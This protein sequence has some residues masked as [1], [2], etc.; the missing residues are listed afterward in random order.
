MYS[1]FKVPGPSILKK[2]TKWLDEEMQNPKRPDGKAIDYGSRRS[3]SPKTDAKVTFH[4]WVVKSYVRNNPEWR[5]HRF[6]KV[7]GRHVCEEYG[8][9]IRRMGRLPPPEP[10]NVK[11][12]VDYVKRMGRLPHGPSWPVNPPDCTAK[13]SSSSSSLKRKAEFGGA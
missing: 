8:D 3:T 13:S 7:F 9:Y 5:T 10:V 6:R 1:T 12:Y 11:E 2:T 4:P